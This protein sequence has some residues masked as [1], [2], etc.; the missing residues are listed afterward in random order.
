MIS[1]LFDHQTFSTQ[2]YG[3]ISRYFANIHHY[4]SQQNDVQ[5]DIS[6]LRSE[7]QYIGDFPA[8]LNNQ[9]GNII[10]KKP[11]RCFKWNKI[12]SKY[13]IQKDDYDVLHPTYYQ[14]YFLKYTK[15]PYVITVHDMIHEIYPEFFEPSDPSALQKRLCVENASHIIAISESTKSDLINFLGVSEDMISVIYHGYDPQLS[16]PPKTTQAPLAFDYLLYVGDRKGYKNWP[17]FVRAITPL[18][19]KNASMKLVCTGGGPFQSAEVEL[20]NRLHVTDQV[21]QLSVSD[22]L[23]SLLYQNALAFIYPSLYEGFGLPI[24]EAFQNQCPVIASNN[25]C[26]KEIGRDAITYFNPDDEESILKAIN[27]VI[28]NS[29]LASDLVIR[30]LSLLPH[31]AMERCMEQTLTVYKTLS[32]PKS[33]K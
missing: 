19:K 30:A 29:Q 8:L 3:G 12:Y 10:L 25:S 15:K 11:T 24:L 6:I 27:S 1:V 7:N 9:F 18:L 5:S 32:R 33:W 14:P 17:R 31:Y 23:L 26:F 2:R 28:S 22:E 13:R 4:I 21:E 16:L 20:L